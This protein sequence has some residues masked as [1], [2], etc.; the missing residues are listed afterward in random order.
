M[1]KVNGSP[2]GSELGLCEK[3]I[4]EVSSFGTDKIREIQILKN[5]ELLHRVT[6]INGDTAKAVFSD[7]CSEPAFYHCR[8]VQKDGHLAVST[9]VWVG[10]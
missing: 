3:R 6:S 1:F 5:A 4:I 2:M 9:P 10:C 8:I 7:K